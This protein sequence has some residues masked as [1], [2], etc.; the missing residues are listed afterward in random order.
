M[1]RILFLYTEL[2]GYFLACIKE[3]A[4]KDVDISIVRWPVNSEA[5][6][7]FE[8]PDNVSVYERSDYTDVQMVD[9]VKDIQADIIYCSG[10]V[11][12]AYVKAC[13][14]YKGA[15]PTVMSMDNQ[16]HG[17][18]RQWLGRASF[19]L[20]Y[21]KAFSH[22][23]VPGEPQKQY[24]IK[25]GFGAEKIKKGFYCADVAAF[26]AIG[27][28][29][30]NEDSEMPKRFIYIGRYI[31]QKGIDILFD[32]FQE[33]Y[34]EGFQEWELHCLGTG[35]LYDQ[36]PVH[37]AIVHHGFVQPSEMMAH[38]TNTSVFV[39]P[40]HFE[41]WGVVVHEMAAA[42]FPMICSSAIGSVGRFVE[43]DKNGFIF[44]AGSKAELKNAMLKMMQSSND[45][46]LKM[47][48]VSHE[49]GLSLTPK[50]WADIASS[51]W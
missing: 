3:L 24:A 41:P 29:R 40:S 19:P 11:D 16:W 51:D 37:K 1:K 13:R 8:F 30:L 50:E 28:K 46:L 22:A 14:Q 49:K 45:E 31:P 6:F 15:I 34:Q 39:L 32:A 42:A 17:N 5:P 26:S 4:G 23:W 48:R 10:W 36:R 2:A 20:L 7:S 44:G 12:K 43:G 38:L 47:A 33:L 25:L 9:L 27:E 35:E 21:K 18:F